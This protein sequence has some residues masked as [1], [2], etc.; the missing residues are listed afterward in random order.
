M[1]LTREEHRPREG[2]VISPRSHTRFKGL[3]LLR[4]TCVFLFLR[5]L[6]TSA[7]H[8]VTALTDAALGNRHPGGLRPLSRPGWGGARGDIFVLSPR[9]WDSG[10]LRIRSPTL[11]PA[12]CFQPG[13]PTGRPG[14]SWE[15]RR[16]AKHGC[17]LRSPHSAGPSEAAAPLKG[18][19]PTCLFPWGWRPSLAYPLV[20]DSPACS[21]VLG[22]PS[23]FARA[24]LTPP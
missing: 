4:P 12:L 24:R 8:H 20:G 15:G 10:L 21:D 3:R 5:L 9:P 7:P 17:P 13:L 23:W 11:L 18:T 14:N 16:K 2:E 1:T 22:H 6:T 19:F